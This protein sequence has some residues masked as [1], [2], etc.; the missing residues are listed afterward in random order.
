MKQLIKLTLIVIAL[1]STLS[2][3]TNKINQ[4]GS[5]LVGYDSTLVPRVI[6]SITDSMKVTTSQYST[7]LFTGSSDSLAVGSVPWTESDLLFE[8]Y[9]IDSVYYAT[10]IYSAKVTFERAGYNLQP[11]GYNVRN[12]RFVGYPMNSSWSETGVSWDSVLAKGHSG[13]NVILSQSMTDTSLSLN[14]DTSIVRQWANATQDTSIRNFGVI[15]KPQNLS[16]ILSLQSSVVASGYLPKIEIDCLVN[17][18]QDTLVASTSYSATVSKTSIQNVAPQGPY[19]IVQS[20]TGL[21]E[22]LMFDL[23]RIPDYSV[24]N[25]AELTLF[26]D[27]KDS[28]YSG[29]GPDS[30]FA[31]YVTDPASHSYYSGL[32]LESVQVG[33][34]YTF[35]VTI[36]VQKMLNT[37][38][39]G[40]IITRASEYDNVDSRF[41]YNEFAPD[42]LKPKLTITYSP[43]VKR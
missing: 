16:G 38:N 8:F 10:T 2:S 13:Q 20:G 14:I 6:D 22:V 35:S 5:W 18:V 21:R 37:G 31:Y 33:N 3:C 11:P 4:T 25:N 41:I 7:Q 43:V 24:V 23:K 34:K 9:G 28:L 39:Y 26:A 42:S 30:L 12:L 36:P 32:L 40:F 19:R 27:P 29:N 15:L 17:G 1:G